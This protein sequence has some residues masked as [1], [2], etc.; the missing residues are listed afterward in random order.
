MFRLAVF[1]GLALLLLTHSCSLGQE[2]EPR[3]V[4][5]DASQSCQVTDADRL[6]HVVVADAPPGLPKAVTADGRA[7]AVVHLSTQQ[8]KSSFLIQLEPYQEGMVSVSLEWPSCALVLP[9]VVVVPARDSLSLGAVV[10]STPAGSAI[11]VAHNRSGLLRSSLL[12]NGVVA[13]SHTAWVSTDSGSRSISFGPYGASRVWPD[14]VYEVEVAELDSST[15]SVVSKQSVVIGAAGSRALG[16]KVRRVQQS[17]EAFRTSVMPLLKRVLSAVL[18]ASACVPNLRSIEE[19]GS[20]AAIDSLLQ[21]IGA[22]AVTTEASLADC[23]EEIL[24][25]ERDYGNWKSQFAHDPWPDL[26]LAFN[27]AVVTALRTVEKWC[28]L[29]NMDVAGVVRSRR[30]LGWLRPGLSELATI[31]KFIK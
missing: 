25:A 4:Y 28:R 29:A 6:L 30:E 15:G 8:D 11:R 14:G 2:S 7:L 12:L 31:V 16:V 3:L 22:V 10:E 26:S 19:A 5:P 18:R 17:A 27:A 24:L 1:A 9:S 21:E 13:E 20:I 23:V